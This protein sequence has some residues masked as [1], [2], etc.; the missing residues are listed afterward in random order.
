[1]NIQTLVNSNLTLVPHLTAKTRYRKKETQ[2]INHRCMINLK[3]RRIEATSSKQWPQI[4]RSLYLPTE[5]PRWWQIKRLRSTQHRRR[6]V[7]RQMLSSSIKRVI[8]WLINKIKKEASGTSQT[9]ASASPSSHISH[10]SIRFHLYLS[11]RIYLSFHKI[12]TAKSIQITNS[13]EP[14]T[15]TLHPSNHS[16]CLPLTSTKTATTT[17]INKYLNY[18]TIKTLILPPP[19]ASKQFT[20]KPN[21]TPT[22][23]TTLTSTSNISW[24]NI[25]ILCKPKTPTSCKISK[26]SVPSS[27]SISSRIRA[28]N[29]IK[30]AKI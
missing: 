12:K 28:N 11:Y 8:K 15:P 3:I 10:L 5:L 13:I 25:C 21:Q 20:I 14:A 18:H 24:C 17:S 2:I 23:W 16:T 26:C 27:F 30:M 9:E 1:M 6:A 29:S 4:K 19:S 22:H 7:R